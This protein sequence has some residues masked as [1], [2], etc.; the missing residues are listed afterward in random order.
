MEGTRRLSIVVGGFVLVSL[1][2]LVVTIVAL[3]SQQG[4]WQD[5]YSL[6]AYFPTVAGLVP[7]A[8]VWLAGTPVGRVDTVAFAEGTDG[9]P[10]V[11]VGLQIDQSASERIREDSVA[12]IGVMGLLGD[13][14]VGISLGTRTARPLAPGARIETLAPTDLYKVIDQGGE[15]LRG[16]SALATNLNAVVGAFQEETGGKEL[17]GS[18]AAIATIVNEIQNG[19]GLLHSFIYDEYEGGGIE[20]IERSLVAFEGIMNEVQSGEGV[21]HSLIYDRVTEQDLV[22]EA[23][24]AGAKLNSILAKVDAG[25]G[26]LGLL[27]NDPTL[28]EE[29]KVLVGGAQRS[30]V[31][32]ALIRLSSGNKADD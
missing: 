8:P 4:S 1:A 20:S 5:R 22:L 3:T 24:G 7:N 25:E 31:V 18:V 26:T 23:L 30:A 6:E 12:A 13:R 9:S 27:V 17:A 10:M 16:I 15:A 11:R 21:L 14:Y 19:D 29:M 28:F 32:R 2:A